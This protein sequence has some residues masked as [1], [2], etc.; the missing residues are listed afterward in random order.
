MLKRLNSYF[1]I[2]SQDTAYSVT[3]PALIVNMIMPFVRVYKICV[4]YM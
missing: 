1:K 2:A 3:D 4:D